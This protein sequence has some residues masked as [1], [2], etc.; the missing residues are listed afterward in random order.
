METKISDLLALQ[1]IERKLA[2]VRGR[3]RSKKNAIAAQQ[4]KLAQFEA[5]R[6]AL[7]ERA[8]TRRVDAE[9]RETELQQRQE[10][11]N[12]QRNALNSAKTNKEYAAVLTQINSLRA[13]NAK[14]EE[15]VLTIMQDVEGIEAEVQALQ[16]QID[17][18]TRR[19]QEVQQN[20]QGDIDRLQGM[21]DE[22]QAE[23]ATAEAAIA[24]EVLA[25]FNRL[26][27]SYDGEA[28]AVIEAHGSSKKS[29]DEFVCG[30]CFMT[31]TPEHVNALSTREGLR[32][33]ESCGRILYLKS[34]SPKAT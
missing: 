31:L 29:P 17:A 26:S 32:T 25:M 9:M 1:A 30:G 11:V 5:D 3:L 24:P 15:E 23:R 18:E 6:D 8:K 28:M 4:R 21:I 7:R 27:E 10:Q 34:Q 2:T 33:C 13:D 19:V 20:A 22:L 12:K 16:E 14:F